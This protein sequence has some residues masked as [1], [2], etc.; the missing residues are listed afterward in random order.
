MRDINIKL[1]ETTGTEMVWKSVD[2]V[3]QDDQ[4]VHYP[5][6]F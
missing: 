1:L 5:I 4:T 2:T 3:M 6:S